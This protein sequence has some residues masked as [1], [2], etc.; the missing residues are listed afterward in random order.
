MSPSAIVPVLLPTIAG[1]FVVLLVA[2]LVLLVV[3]GGK[4]APRQDCSQ[5]R[6]A[7][8]PAAD[9]QRQ[10]QCAD[11]HQQLIAAGIVQPTLDFDATSVEIASP[12]G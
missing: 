2:K 5:P 6:P 1:F 4:R 7:Q 8:Q 10:Q 3:R 9:H 12:T 11:Y